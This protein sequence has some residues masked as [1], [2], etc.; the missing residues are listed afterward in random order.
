MKEYIAK[1]GGRYTYNDDLLNLQELA[2]SMTSIFEGCSNFIISGCEVADGRITPGYVWIGGRVRPF[3]G[4]AEVS[5]PYYIYEKNHYETIAYAGDVNKHG[6]CCYLCSGA[7][8]VPQTEDEVTGALPG[9][10]E[11]HEDYAPRFIDKFIG[12]YAVL[13]ESPFARQTVH[14][15]LTLAGSVSVEKQFECKTA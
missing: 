7:T 11:L 6:R 3:E 14:K 15:D 10:I 8:S 13:L 12:R 4:A 5:L 9:Y 1:T 2:R